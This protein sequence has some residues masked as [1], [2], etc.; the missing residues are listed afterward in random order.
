MKRFVHALAFCVLLF[1][2]Q[3]GWAQFV[4]AYGGQ[5]TVYG[6]DSNCPLIISGSTTM[7][8]D[9]ALIALNIAQNIPVIASFS[10]D[11]G[12]VINDGT[13]VTS[14]PVCTTINTSV[15]SPPP[16]HFN[17][18]YTPGVHIFTTIFSAC[19]GGL[20]IPYKVATLRVNVP[21]PPP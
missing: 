13:A 5:A 18:N 6:P 10:G 17:T 9:A 1:I 14:L 12:A 4:C 20:Y 2:S 21:P 15:V 16:L 3:N 11:I 8:I 7:H 19:D